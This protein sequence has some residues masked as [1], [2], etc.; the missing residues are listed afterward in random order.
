MKY[1]FSTSLQVTFDVYHLY[2]IASYYDVIYS[3]SPKWNVAYLKVF[4]PHPPCI[5][6]FLVIENNLRK[7]SMQ[8]K[9]MSRITLRF[10]IWED[11]RD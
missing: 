11:N 8:K 3:T 6:P 7:N 5:H 2:Y 4:F 9:K 10:K 1:A